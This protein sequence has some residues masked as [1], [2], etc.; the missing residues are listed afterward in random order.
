MNKKLILGFFLLLATIFISCDTLMQALQTASSYASSNSGSLSQSEVVSALKQ[1]LEIGAKYAT[2]QLHKTNGYYGNKAIKILLPTQI[3]SALDYAL[4]NPTVKRLGIDKILKKKIDQVVLSMNRAAEKEAI[5]AQP[6]FI[7][8][9][10]NLSIVQGYS[11]LKGQDPRHKIAGFDSTAATHYLELKT[12]NQLF[13][14][15]KPKINDAL[16]KDLLGIGLSTNQLWNQLTKYYNAYVATLLNRPKITYSLADYATNKALDG[17][18]YTIG[19]EEKK[20][21]QNPYKWSSDLIK[22]VFGSVYKQS[23]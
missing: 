18:F 1:A 19:Q 11:I 9:I 16:N 5:Q 14:L 12:R 17:L 7:N 20:I 6:I 13:N 8:A 10:K 21:R 3:Q 23:R 2:E 4:N 22:K 15:Y